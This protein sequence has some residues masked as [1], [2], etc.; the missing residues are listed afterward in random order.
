M[1]GSSMWM[2]NVGMT[3]PSMLMASAMDRGQRRRN[4]SRPH[5]MASV[6][7]PAAALEGLIRRE[8][9]VPTPRDSATISTA[10]RA[11][12]PKGQAQSP[13]RMSANVPPGV[14]PGHQPWV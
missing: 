8:S 2:P 9:T 6:V 1:T 3:A 7:I 12:M 14:D 10:P 5:A 13:R 11:R 4:T